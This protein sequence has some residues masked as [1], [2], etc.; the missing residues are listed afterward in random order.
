MSSHLYHTD[1]E[2][3]RTYLLG[4]FFADY[5]AAPGIQSATYDAKKT[6]GWG[7]RQVHPAIGAQW[8]L[9][10]VRLSTGT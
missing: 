1:G 6:T 9:G 3:A 5:H 10:A 2:S 4:Q 8:K 7:G